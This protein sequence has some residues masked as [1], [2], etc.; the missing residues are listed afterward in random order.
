MHYTSSQIP[1]NTICMQMHVWWIHFLMWYQQIERGTKNTNTKNKNN[2]QCKHGPWMS[3]SIFLA[4]FVSVVDCCTRKQWHTAKGKSS[5]SWLNVLFCLEDHMQPIVAILYSL[6]I[7]RVVYVYLWVR[8][9]V[10]FV[11]DWFFGDKWSFHFL[12]SGTFVWCRK[13]FCFVLFGCVKPRSPR[14]GSAWTNIAVDCLN[15]VRYR[16]FT[17]LYVLHANDSYD[18]CL[19]FIRRNS[20]LLLQ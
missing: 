2:M 18:Y 8:S 5:F 11:V 15:M 16:Y 14:S 1:Q 9:D 13:S 7:C 12:I 4:S 10:H 6:S 20:S 3:I 19:C 17:L